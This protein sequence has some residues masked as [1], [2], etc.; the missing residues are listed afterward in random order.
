M[1]D[2]DGL[3]SGLTLSYPGDHPPGARRSSACARTCTR[4]AGMYMVLKNDDVIF[5][6][7]TTVNIDPD[8]ETL[9]EI[10]IQI[11]DAARE[12]DIEPR[13]AMLS[14]SNFGSARIREPR[15]SR[16]GGAR[17]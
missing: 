13:V 17:S 3:V 11:A 4:A 15:R 10:A 12:F 9:A 5:F 7:D 16:A 2:A 6:A 1:G 8:A 14:F